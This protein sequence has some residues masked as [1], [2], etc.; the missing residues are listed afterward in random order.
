MSKIKITISCMR[1]SLGLKFSFLDAFSLIRISFGLLICFVK[2][3]ELFR[4]I[5]SILSPKKTDGDCGGLN[6]V[7]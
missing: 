1:V 3:G 7:I 2:I 6:E 5:F 4:L